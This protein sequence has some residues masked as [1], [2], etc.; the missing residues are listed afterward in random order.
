MSMQQSAPFFR[1]TDI[2]KSYLM[3]GEWTPVLKGVSLS[4]EPGEFLSILGPSGSG[5]STL[6]HLMGIDHERLTYTF[7]GRRYRLTDVAGKVV[8]GLLA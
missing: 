8:K 3:G 4:L 6:L 2:T 7:Q 1:M 5:K